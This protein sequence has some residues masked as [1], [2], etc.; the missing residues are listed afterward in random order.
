MA[1][2]LHHGFTTQ[3]QPWRLGSSLSHLLGNSRTRGGR[4]LPPGASPRVGGSV[5]NGWIDQL[6]LGSQGVYLCPWGALGRAPPCLARDLPWER[7]ELGF[8]KIS[9]VQ[10]FL[11]RNSSLP[12]P[13]LTHL[14]SKI[15]Q[16]RCPGCM[17]RNFL[18]LWYSFLS[19]EM[20][21][22]S[23]NRPWKIICSDFRLT[24]SRDFEGHI[25]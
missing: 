22:R 2:E 17:A 14:D 21:I 1:P 4:R 8:H 23:P 6:S 9:L 24:R 19:L 11:I 7:R 13:Y 18:P 3:G 16:I 15:M 12:A 10:I 5:M 25:S 20:K